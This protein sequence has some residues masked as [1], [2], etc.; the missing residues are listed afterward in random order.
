[1]PDWV[2]DFG[3]DLRHAARLFRRQPG[4]AVTAILTLALGLGSATA[5]F[6]WVD[7]M[8][9]RPLLV[10]EPG[11]VFNLGERSENGRVRMAFSYPEYLTYRQL[12]RVFE[13]LVAFD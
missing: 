3:W 10:R 11:R 6:T 7:R 8:F 1:M 4:F 9:L 5:L 13:G 12:N 2:N